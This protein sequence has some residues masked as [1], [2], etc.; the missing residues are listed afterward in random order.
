MVKVMKIIEQLD[1]NNSG[2]PQNSVIDSQ[3]LMD[4]DR[5]GHP[6]MSM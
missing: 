5:R 2:I 6:D 3:L 1:D 4:E